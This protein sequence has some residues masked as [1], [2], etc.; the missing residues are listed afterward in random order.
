MAT[1]DHSQIPTILGD[2]QAILYQVMMSEHSPD[3]A[4]EDLDK[5]LSIQLAALVH[6]NQYNL[7][8]HLYRRYHDS[9]NANFEMERSSIESI[10][11]MFYSLWKALEP[12]LSIHAFDLKHSEYEHEILRPTNYMNSSSIFTIE[13]V[14]DNLQS[15]Q[16]RKNDF[17][18]PTLID[19]LAGELIISTRDKV[20]FML[21]SGSFE[22]IQDSSTA[23][24]LGFSD[25]QSAIDFCKKRGWEVERFDN[26]VYLIPLVSEHHYPTTIGENRKQRD[27]ID[28]LTQLVGFLEVERMNA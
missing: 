13:K 22:A 24:L 4:P 20:L 10:F 14:Y 8:R 23:L 3:I 26:K 2:N 5:S 11:P 15:C 27:L 19:S 17:Y 9:Q 25:N 12:L 21:E 28:R 1:S 7:A 6:N 18:N 16:S